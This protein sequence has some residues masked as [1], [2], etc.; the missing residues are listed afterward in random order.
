MFSY[1]DNKRDTHAKDCTLQQFERLCASPR[2]LNLCAR[3]AQGDKEAKGE[4]PCV[5]WQ[6]HFTPGQTRHVDHCHPTGLVMLDLDHLHEHYGL[7]PRQLY[8]RL[9]REHAPLMRARCR[10]AHMTPSTDGLRLVM[11]M[12]PTELQQAVAG[13]LT[14]AEVQE[15]LYA[16][17]G[18]TDYDGVCHDWSRLS[19]CVPRSYYFYLDESVFNPLAEEQ[20]LSQAGRSIKSDGTRQ[21]PQP[22]LYAD[23]ETAGTEGAAGSQPVPQRQPT[24]FPSTFHGIAYTTIV[25]RL[26]AKLHPA[27]VEEGERNSTLFTL[28]LRLRH[29]CDFS[30]EWLYQVAPRTWGLPETE[31]WD[32]CQKAA[33]RERGEMPRVLSSL[34]SRLEAEQQ[35]AATDGK[36]AATEGTKGGGHALPP[37]PPI[38]SEYAATAPASFRV[39]MVLSL[40]PMLGTLMSRLRATYLDGELQSPQFYVVIKAPSSSGKGFARR[41]V[42]ELM[43]PVSQ[44]DKLSTDRER[45][46]QRQLKLLKLLKKPKLKESDLPHEPVVVKRM[47]A[48]ATSTSKLLMR[49]EQAQGL[50]LFTFLEEIDSLSKS[51][52]QNW[53]SRSDVLRL[54]FD[55]A[56]YSQDYVSEDSY[57]GTVDVCY[58]LLLSGTPEAVDNFFGSPENGLVGRFI[59]VGLPQMLGQKMPV[60]RPMDAPTRSYVEARI[61]SLHDELC[62]SAD[63]VMRPTCEVSLP[64][65]CKAIAKWNEQQRLRS[66]K[67]HSEALAVFYRRAAVYGF[68]AG[69]VAYYL[70]GERNDPATQA[71]VKRF[72]QWVADQVLD[73]LLTNYGQAM[74]ELMERRAATV[75]QQQAHRYRLMGQTLYDLLPPVFGR[76]QLEALLAASGKKTPVRQIVYNWRLNGLISELSADQYAKKENKR[77]KGNKQ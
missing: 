77:K 2:V 53:N 69:M 72:A 25:E 51:S 70:W 37:L 12:T 21:Q 39:P 1:F 44:L 9:I 62:C 55:N 58:N 31:I 24:A 67:Q 65:L 49:M 50:H 3:V 8:E 73:A 59:F 63:L 7:T 34:L 29:I 68:R 26:L 17:L 33:N 28:M 47:M 23:L 16:Q 48:A 57:S 13:E 20:P 46:Y 18:L 41:V 45:E 74:D 54:G 75:E 6:S 10:V 64:W 38:I 40:L 30:A 42:K 56:T 32:V 36:P 76:S 5:S 35:P 61:E 15:R 52:Q 4:L 66:V 60:F 22:T 14:L 43:R 71:H 11:A 19:F 27:P